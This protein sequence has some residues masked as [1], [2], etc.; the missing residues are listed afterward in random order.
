MKRLYLLLF[1]L[2][3]FISASAQNEKGQVYLKNGNMLKGRYQ[4]LDGFKTLRVE[5]G[6][7][8]W[9]FKAEEVDKVVGRSA[10][11]MA[12]PES[13][14]SPSGIFYRTELG[15]LAGNS[16]NSQPKPFS[17]TLKMLIR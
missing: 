13:L 4:W 2:L 8:V 17:F 5:S 6:G 14:P 9:N 12:A 7:N 11:A 16:Q 1:V 3:I 15:I 10:S